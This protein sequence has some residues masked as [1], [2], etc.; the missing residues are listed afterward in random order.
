MK[1]KKGVR[2]LFAIIAILLS[3]FPTISQG[4]QV[5]MPFNTAQDQAIRQKMVATNNVWFSYLLKYASDSTGQTGIENQG[6]A[7]AYA[8]LY[9]GN[10]KYAQNAW[11][12]IKPYAEARTLPCGNNNNS[13]RIYF[14]LYAICFRILYSTLS[15]SDQQ[16]YIAWMNGIAQRARTGFFSG[17]ANGLIG[18]YL[19]LCL[20]SLIS[21]PDNPQASTM[22]SGTWDDSGAW[23]PYGGL[24][25]DAT[26]G[27]R[28]SAR[29]AI[30]DYV[31]RTCPTPTSGGVWLEG[32]QYFN[33]S[34]EPLLL[35]TLAINEITGQDHFPEVTAALPQIGQ[36]AI[37]ILTNSLIDEF[38]FG[39][40][41]FPH[42]LHI[43]DTLCT[44]TMLARQLEGTG[45]GAEL[46]WLVNYWASLY[47]YRSYACRMYLCMD[48]FAPATDFRSETWP[49]NGSGLSVWRSGWD[50]TGDSVFGVNTDPMSLVDHTQQ[51]EVFRSFRLY[52]K[53]EWALTHP[54]TY[55]GMG[56]DENGNNTVVAGGLGVM[57]QHAATAWED[58][59][60][61]CYQRSET[62]GSPY[63]SN[64][65]TPPPAYISEQTGSVLYV[66]GVNK[67]ADVLIVADRVNATNPML[68]GS[69]LNDWRSWDAANI[70][71]AE[72]SVFPF[73][74]LQWTL[75]MP[76]APAIQN[77]AIAW[78][79]AGGQYVVSQELA[80]S[81][82]QT[83]FSIVNE[84]ATD[85]LGN[86]LYFNYGGVPN[87]ER[88]YQVRETFSDD[89]AWHF[90]LHALCIYDNSTP[91]IGRVDGNGI[92]GALVCPGKEAATLAVFSNNAASRLVES[93]YS[94]SFT[95][96]ARETDAYLLDLDPTLSWTIQIDGGQPFAAQFGSGGVV[97]A[98]ISGSGQHTLT[99]K[100]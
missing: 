61:Y 7:A 32:T 90:L 84:S 96:T 76:I 16:L 5:P 57:W 50:T 3:I 9:T 28:G 83:A 93:S 79:T 29:N 91:A 100:P 80:P 95:I 88:K 77:G 82:T 67:T 58:G 81:P 97:R 73:G 72:T 45:V 8:Y 74:P 25:Y 65:Y 12:A 51:D 75:H 31:T 6:T 55:G 99:V 69:F 89:N 41:G 24:D 44:M 71:N 15:S 53:G 54:I 23:K 33:A 49:V 19:G 86:Y 46:Q 62:S 40:D 37:G 52:R 26:L 27:P 39:D 60:N 20:W 11:S 59:S 38:Q 47:G 85:S 36:A 68:A 48:P 17:N 22:L 66:H 30:Y 63:N 21:A 78:K 34:L 1:Q 10:P 4:Q 98:V 42:Q 43:A 94:L 18:E 70:Q 64:Y 13:I 35:Y 92:S 2:V 56:C 87:T 14:G